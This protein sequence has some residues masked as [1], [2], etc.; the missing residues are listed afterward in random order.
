MWFTRISIG[1]PVLATMMMVA[2]VVL[3]LFS[4]QRL[5]VDQFPDVTFPIVVVQ[6]EYPGAAPETVESV[7][8]KLDMEAAE[9][10]S[11]AAKIFEKAVFGFQAIVVGIGAVVALSRGA[12][13]LKAT[14][15]GSRGIGFGGA[16]APKTPIAPTMG[17]GGSA[18]ALGGMAGGGLS[19]IASGLASFANPAAL[20]GLAAITAAVIGLGYAFKVAGPAMEPFGKML[21]SILGGM[22]DVI[23][24]VVTAM[25]ELV[26]TLSNLNPANTALMGAA[27]VSMAAGLTTLG[28]AALVSSPGLL[29]LAGMKKLGILPTDT[30]EAK[31]PS[32]N[33]TAT[34]ET[35][36]TQ[37]KDNMSGQLAAIAIASNVTNQ[38][39][40]E[41]IRQATVSNQKLEALAKQIITVNMDGQRVGNIIKRSAMVASTG[42]STARSNG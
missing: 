1:N 21:R 29:A 25:G 34:T 19:G 30:T 41:L 37:A 28:A 24:S 33:I 8:A 14:G 3:G 5:R 31:E 12:A 10:Q 22:G 36:P 20:V 15:L 40:S 23:S 39:L 38:K 32:G 26:S 11:N 2:F 4:Y 9:L 18:S 42:A 13:L 6:T 17:A 35:Q 7:S 27:M 16:S